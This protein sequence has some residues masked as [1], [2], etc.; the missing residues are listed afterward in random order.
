MATQLTVAVSAFPQTSGLRSSKP[1]AY[2][3]L[4]PYLPRFPRWHP[5]NT[6]RSWSWEAISSPQESLFPPDRA[7]PSEVFTCTPSPLG[8]L[9]NSWA[10]GV[11]VPHTQPQ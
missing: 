4:P 5:G 10:H 9:L 7:P 1:Q 6:K 3:C 8:F 11:S 2:S